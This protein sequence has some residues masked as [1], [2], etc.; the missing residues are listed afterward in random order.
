MIACVQGR[1]GHAN[2][3]AIER[4][5]PMVLKVCEDFEAHPVDMVG[6]DDHVHLPVNGNTSLRLANTQGRSTDSMARRYP[7]PA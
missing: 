3:D 1:D 7:S 2:G 5:H 4:L 6:E